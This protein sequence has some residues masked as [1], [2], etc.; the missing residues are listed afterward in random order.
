MIRILH[1]DASLLAVDKPDGVPTIPGY[2]PDAHPVQQRVE[3]Q[4]GQRLW[5]VHRLDKD[6]SGV[7]LFAKTA[8]AHRHLNAQFSTR[9]VDKRYA[10]LVHG[11]PR[12]AEG[13]I[14]APLRKYGSG[15]MGVDA[16]RG[17]ASQTQYRVIESF[18]G[19][20]LVEA[21]PVTGRR[22]Q[23]R[24]HLYHLGHPIVGDPL[25]GDA[26][27][28]SGYV[29]LYLHARRIRITH[30]G[31]HNLHIEAPLPATFEEA[32]AHARAGTLLAASGSA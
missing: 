21:S 20:T 24:V 5:V 9:A 28:R 29:R 11:V 14:D 3:D 8:E 16:R 17:K 31:G 2:D 26:A 13:C 10:A 27:L 32:L 4:I 23:I 7:L 18:A 12:A 1:E 6:V 30:P 19:C 25:Y 15:R 22:H